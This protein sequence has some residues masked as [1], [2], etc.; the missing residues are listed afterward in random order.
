MGFWQLLLAIVFLASYSV[1]SSTLFGGRGRLRA[2]GVALVAAGG[3]TALTNPWEHGLL[4]VAGAIGGLGLFSA[5]GWILSTAFKLP[6][7]S[8]AVDDEGVVTAEPAA[9][10]A[11]I[12]A[13]ARAPQHTHIPAA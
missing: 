12:S 5:I 10:P 2:G 1:A 13:P 7:G 9:E 8:V 11:V 3:F 4:M 6:R